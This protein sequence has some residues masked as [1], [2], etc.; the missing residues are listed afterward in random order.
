MSR[1]ARFPM[2][3]LAKPV[4]AMLIG[5]AASS[6]TSA[7]YVYHLIVRSIALKGKSLLF[8]ACVPPRSP[9]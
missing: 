6:S 8:G 5:R 9:R 2:I 3:T 7:S 4:T 1:G